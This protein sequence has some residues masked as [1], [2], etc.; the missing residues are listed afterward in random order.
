[1]LAWPVQL[2]VLRAALLKEYSSTDP[3]TGYMTMRLT[4]SMQLPGGIV[5]QP[6]A[7][8]PLERD[9]LMSF[10]HALAKI[11]PCSTCRESYARY[12]EQDP[13]EQSQN[14]FVWFWELKNKV[15]R[16]LGRDM[17]TQGLPLEKYE[18]RL[19]TLSSFTSTDQVWDLLC[20]FAINYPELPPPQDTT[21]EQQRH[22]KEHD[23]VLKRRA[24]FQLLAVLSI[25]LGRLQT[26]H[27]MAK[28]LD[29]M[30][31][32]TRDLSSR[33]QFLSWI[34][35]QRQAWAAF[36]HGLAYSYNDTL[37]RFSPSPSQTVAP[38]GKYTCPNPALLP[39]GTSTPAPS[40]HE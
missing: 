27:T 23:V 26:H 7:P 15:N 16:K 34:V 13:P 17:S 10:F 28:Y 2:D 4:T 38:D 21:D 25:F 39:S 29:P 6:L 3:Y 18:K 37:E 1:M 14:L 9:L 35:Q 31:L 19:R 30:T 40:T 32:T 8:D 24:Y 5:G 11:Y 33:Q 12:I 20:I 22:A 36:T